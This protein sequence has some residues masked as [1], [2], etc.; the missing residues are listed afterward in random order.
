MLA[1]RCRARPWPRAGWIAIMALA[2][3]ADAA[4]DVGRSRM[5]PHTSRAH[6]AN[7]RHERLDAAGHGGSWRRV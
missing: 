2:A 4:S 6:I 5:R 3:G 1:A 7:E